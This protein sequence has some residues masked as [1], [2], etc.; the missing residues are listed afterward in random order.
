LPARIRVLIADDHPVVREGL[1][2]FLQLQ[3]D[4]D[5]VG[6]AADGREAVAMAEATQPDVLLLDVVMPAMDG[7]EALRRI[8]VVAPATRVIVLTTFADD[9]R[10]FPAIQAGAAA[11]LLKDVRPHELADAIRTVHGG[12]SLLHPTVAAKVMHEVSQRERRA[13]EL[14]TLTARELEVLRLIARG[15]SNR[16]IARELEVSEKTVKT[17]VSNILGKLGVADRTQAALWAVRER[18]V[19]LE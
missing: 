13:P 12:E 2:S 4:L 16:E 1:L 9:G 14:E 17:H 6:T 5:V 3:D 18:L 11:Y 7:V 8:R 10:V 15:R 19:E